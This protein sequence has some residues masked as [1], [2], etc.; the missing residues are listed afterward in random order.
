M[1]PKEKEKKAK[2]QFLKSFGAHIKQVRIEKGLS[3]A[4]LAGMLLMDQ[5]N[6]TRI[7][8][9]RVNVSI[10]FVKQV[11]NA[12]EISFERMFKDFEY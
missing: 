1:S 10:Y 12:L 8:K 7:E 4:D 11:C 3:G 5:P 2:E 6:L 9:G